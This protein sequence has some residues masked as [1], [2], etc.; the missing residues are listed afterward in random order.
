MRGLDPNFLQVTKMC[1]M[2]KDGNAAQLVNML[3]KRK[4]TKLVYKKTIQINGLFGI[5]KDK[6]K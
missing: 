1:L 4:V 5:E 2:V 3:L 6:T